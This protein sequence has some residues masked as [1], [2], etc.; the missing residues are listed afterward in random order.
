MQQAQAQEQPIQKARQSVQ[1]PQTFQQM[2]G[3]NQTIPL[4]QTVPIVPGAQVNQQMI[5]PTQA[6]PWNH[7]MTQPAAS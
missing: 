4:D 2:G 1:Q 6:V 3:Y 5:R 7:Q